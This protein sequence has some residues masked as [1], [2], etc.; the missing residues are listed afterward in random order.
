MELRHLRYFV[1]I[2]DAMSFTKAAAHL[3]LAQPS[4]T[5]QIKNLE[6]EIGVALFDRVHNRVELTAEGQRFLV[7]VRKILALCAET[8][9]AVQRMKQGESS[10]L[11]IGYVANLHDHLLPATLAA[12]RQQYP[13]VG[14]NLFDMSSADQVRALA[15]SEID[16]GFIG[17]SPSI[18]V[19]GLSVE[20]VTYDS[21]L[22]AL[23]ARHPLG[24]APE[25]RLTDLAAHFFIGMSDRTHPGSREWLLQTCRMAGFEGR[26][27]QEA[28]TEATAIQ[29]VAG[30][31]G[32]ALLPE[33]SAGL[34]HEGVIFHPLSPALRR[35]SV[36][37]WRSENSSRELHEYIKI[38]KKLS[39]ASPSEKN[40]SPLPP[41]SPRKKLRPA[42]TRQQASRSQPHP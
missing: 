21:M 14:L 4:L 33:Q 17:L 8:V 13:K 27:L 35:P 10:Q 32:V 2:A 18:S 20:R 39:P 5:R 16:L 25:V 6:S 42:N 31:L 19:P 7:D 29:F 3:R 11:N 41:P 22:V 40:I 37:A 23:P 24:R 12:F 1:A 15:A 30:G 28:D 36:I 38:A 34:P 26:I 9:T